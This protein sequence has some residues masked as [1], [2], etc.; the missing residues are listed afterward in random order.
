MNKTIKGAV[1]GG[2]LGITAAVALAVAN[3]F[4][5]SRS[6]GGVVEP[7]ICFAERLWNLQRVQ[8]VHAPGCNNNIL[9]SI[10]L[11]LLV[12]VLGGSLI[13]SLSLITKDTQKQSKDSCAEH[14]SA[15]TPPTPV[16]GIEPP[17]APVEKK[18]TVPSISLPSIS[19]QI[20]QGVNRLKGINWNTIA[21]G[22]TVAGGILVIGFGA[23]NLLKV[24]TS[25]SQEGETNPTN[26]EQNANIYP[27]PEYQQ[28][29]PYEEVFDGATVYKIC[30]NGSNYNS[31]VRMNGNGGRGWG[32]V[33]DGRSLLHPDKLPYRELQRLKNLMRDYCP[34][35]LYIQ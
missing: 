4:V 30:E 17:T 22:T 32:A 9:N 7:R 31:M 28:E 27:D 10:P 21:K 13:S 1:I 14:A 3:E 8:I 2:V 15:S 5:W 11:C 18:L 29:D 12:G 26:Q 33:L 24:A 23:I 16:A 19:P 20:N 35:A 6:S 34:D 25:N